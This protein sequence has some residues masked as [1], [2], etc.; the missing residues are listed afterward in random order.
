MYE[1]DAGYIIKADRAYMSSKDLNSFN[2]SLVITILPKTDTYMDTKHVN[3]MPS[4]VHIRITFRSTICLIALIYR[5]LLQ[6]NIK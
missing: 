4:L 3:I 2:I 6:R 1:K 5:K